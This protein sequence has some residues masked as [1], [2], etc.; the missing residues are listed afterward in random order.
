[1]S[2]QT[3]EQKITSAPDS[4]GVYL[5]RDKRNRPIYIGKAKNIRK[6]LRSYM[7]MTVG[8]DIRK[9]EMVNTAADVTYIIT[10]NELEA[11]AL[12]ANLIKQDRPKYNILLRD[13]K[14]YPYLRIDLRDEWPY[15]EIVR[16]VKKDGALYFGPYI[17]AGA[18]HETLALIRKYF[19]LRLCKYDLS[20]IERPC[21]QH[22]MGRCLAPC[23]GIISRESYMDAVNNVIL[24]LK[25]K[26]KRLL[27]LL[28]NQMAGLSRKEMY[29]E[30]AT[31]R[32]RIAAIEA[33][34][35][36]QKVVSPRLGEMD[37]IGYAVKGNDIAFIVLF[38]RNGIMTGSKEFY[39]QNVADINRKELIH[40]FI[41][42]L[43]AG[44]LVPPSHVLVPVTPEDDRTL[45]Q[46][47]SDRRGAP[48]AI[49]TAFRGLKKDLLAMAEENASEFVSRYR[50]RDHESLIQEVQ[51]FLGISRLPE[52]IGAFDISTLHGSESR[53]AYIAWEYGYFQKQRYRFVKIRSV[54]GVD[55]YAMMKETVS[56]ILKRLGSHVPSLL[57]IDGGKGQ[58]DAAVQA[59]KEMV[60][61]DPPDV[62]AIAKDPDRVFAPWLNDPLRI[63]DSRAVSLFLGGI[64]DEVH[65][66]AITQHRKARKKA[67]LT[68]SLEDI[69]GI[70][71]KRRLALLKHFGSLDAIRN[72][73]IDEISRVEGFTLALGEKVKAFL[74][75]Q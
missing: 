25:G 55:D 72:A 50:I 41:E 19:Y 1:M 53:G 63:D 36:K 17:P 59:L 46:W 12:E 70:G 73:S 71:R 56:R 6:R 61:E 18:M 49:T 51:A 29:E 74:N 33:I 15:L 3:L 39:V 65:R 16:R 75:Q 54:T 14:N 27:D 22:Q 62:I 23:S 9:R 69:K 60:I 43:Y 48:V 34:W 32:D 4:P 26:D 20:K 35:E 21:V 11:L 2:D 28:K 44:S 66:Y 30:A 13:D 8:L 52:A 42:T 67:L 45:S 24:F 7:S 38:I 64:R 31:V 68:S 40:S 57:I 5:F 58:L 10:A 37:V 47:L